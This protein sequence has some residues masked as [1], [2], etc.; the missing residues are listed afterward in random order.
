MIW[1]GFGSDNHAGAHPKVMEAVVAANEGH[2][3]AYGDDPW[4]ERAREVV[5]ARLG[6]DCEVALVMN[7]TGANCV[8]FA[9]TARPWDSVVCAKTAHINEDECGAPERVGGVKLVPVGTADGKLTP[10]LV[11]PHLRGFGFEHHSQP[12]LISISNLSELGTAYTPDETRTLADLAHSHGML[13]HVD[14]ARLANAAAWLGRGLDEVTTVAGADCVSLGGTKNGMLFGEAVVLAG[15]VPSDA[16]AYARK[17]STQL[18]SKMRFIAAQLVVLYEGDLWLE[19]ATH[20][21]AMAARLAQ[22]ARSAGIELAQEP[23][24]NEVFAL[25]PADLIGPLSERFRFHLWDASRGVV[26][27][28]CSWDTTEADVDA[29]LDALGA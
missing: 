28:V 25:L 4:T 8:C 13:L 10:D 29:L 17:Q 18:A 7:G 12:R 22:G 23:Q 11:T 6:A 3:R 1:R 14:G 15:G 21:N 19:L 16:V 20:A 9:A 26:R 24:G 27:W 5:R 2:A